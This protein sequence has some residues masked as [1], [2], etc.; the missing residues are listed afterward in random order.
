VPWSLVACS[1]IAVVLV[2]CYFGRALYQMSGWHLAVW[3]HLNSIIGKFLVK[4]LVGCT[5]YI[6]RV[7]LDLSIGVGLRAAE[8]GGFTQ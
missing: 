2:A 6:D 8:W 7:V 5:Y 3:L 4:C 1:L